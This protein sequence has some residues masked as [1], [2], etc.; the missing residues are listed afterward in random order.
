[1]P[2]FSKFSAFVS[3]AA[4]SGLSVVDPDIEAFEALNLLQTSARPSRGLASEAIRAVKE[5]EDPFNNHDDDSGPRAE[6]PPGSLR[7]DYD[8]QGQEPQTTQNLK[9]KKMLYRNLGG[10]GPH[11]SQPPNVRYKNVAKTLDGS[12]VD[13]ILESLNFVT[14][15]PKKVGLFGDSAVVNIKNG[16]TVDFTARFVDSET[17]NP[18]KLG[19]FHLSVMDID[20]GKE[21]GQEELTIGGFSDYYLLDETELTKVEMDDGRTRF[22]AGEPG[23]GADNPVDPLMLTDV[24]AKR[25]VSFQFPGGLDRFE[26]SYKVAKVAYDDYDAESEGRHFFLSGMSSLYFCEADPVVIDYNMANVAYSNLGGLGPDFDSPPALRFNKIA[27]IENDQTL[28]MTVTN[29]TRYFPANTANNGLN[30][31]FAQVNI[32][33]GTTTRFRFTFLKHGTD[34]PYEMDWAYLSIFDLDHGKKADKY[35]ETIELRGFVTHYLTETSELEVTHHGEKWYTYGSTTWGTGKDNP[36]DP[37]HMTQQQMDRSVTILY[38]SI[39]SFDAKFGA[40]NP[41][42][43][44]RNFLFSGKSALVFC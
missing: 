19:P 9:F 13:M 22:I 42:Q 24:Q 41:K 5:G 3:V 8:V 7:A 2:L 4:A 38:H 1:M 26:F 33:G 15:K 10:L 25:T 6:S 12:P 23:T 36:S 14:A 21:G 17:S 18:V 44:G 39:S 20:T 32:G 35:K 28:D 30:G 34:E 16:H 27:H 37:M 31:Q 43:D 40:G 11:T 29:L